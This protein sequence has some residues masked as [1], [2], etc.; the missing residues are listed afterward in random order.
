MLRQ[1]RATSDLLRPCLIPETK[2]HETRPVSEVDK[3]LSPAGT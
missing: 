3:H 1:R 2:F